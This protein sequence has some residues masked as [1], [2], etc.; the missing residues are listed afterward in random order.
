VMGT[1]AFS[2]EKTLLVGFS[3]A[4]IPQ[5]TASKESIPSMSTQLNT[6]T[7]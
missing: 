5:K 3:L 7:S 6:Q 1:P 4:H 2:G